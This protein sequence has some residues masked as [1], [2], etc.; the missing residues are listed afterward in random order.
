MTFVK[1]KPIEENDM[2]I[3]CGTCSP[4]T[5]ILEMGRIL[6]VGFGLCNATKDGVFIYDEQDVEDGQEYPNAQWLESVAKNDPDHDYRVSFYTPLHDEVYQ[7]QGDD[8]WVM[9]ES[10]PGFA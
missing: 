10:G 3:G 7:R 9:I 8:Y 1:Q 6:A 2:H 5:H 4:V